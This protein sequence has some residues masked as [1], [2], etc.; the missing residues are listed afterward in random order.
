MLKALL[1]RLSATF[2]LQ[3][4]RNDTSEECATIPPAWLIRTET[5]AEPRPINNTPAV[6]VRL[7]TCL[8]KLH[9]TSCWTVACQTLLL[10]RLPLHQREAP[11]GYY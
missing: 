7:F 11:S 3:R 10:A 9:K 6:G 8:K 1:V 5:K 4:T 2:D